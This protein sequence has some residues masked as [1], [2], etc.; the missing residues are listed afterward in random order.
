MVL[1][2]DSLSFLFHSLCLVVRLLAPNRNLCLEGQLTVRWRTCTC[3]AAV[4][5]TT[6]RAWRFGGS[7]LAFTSSAKL[8][9][10]F[11][12]AIC[13]ACRPGNRTLH[14]DSRLRPP[15]DCASRAL[16]VRLVARAV[17]SYCGRFDTFI[18][19][20]SRAVGRSN[21]RDRTHYGVCASLERA[22]AISD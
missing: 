19:P 22:G 7:A 12:A 15:G 10:P 6:Y 4:C 11:L 8:V 17:S 5:R 13:R 16:P 1:P 3:R 14:T 20:L 2:V 18:R 21:R 9:V